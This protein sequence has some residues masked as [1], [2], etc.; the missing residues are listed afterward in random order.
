MI[1]QNLFNYFSVIV[2]S[3]DERSI[4]VAWDYSCNHPGVFYKVYLEHL[5]WKACATGQKDNTRGPGTVKTLTKQSCKPMFHSPTTVELCREYG[6]CCCWS[7]VEEYVGSI[8][9]LSSPHLVDNCTREIS[10]QGE[11]WLPLV[12]LLLYS[13]CCYIRQR[14]GS[15]TLNP[16]VI[17]S[18]FNCL[19]F[20][21]NIALFTWTDILWYIFATTVGIQI[22]NIQIMEPFK[23][24]TVYYWGAH[25]PIKVCYSTNQLHFLSVTQPMTWIMDFQSVQARA[26]Q[27]VAHQLE[28]P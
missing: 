19:V 28:V 16:S 1:A 7:T 15:L 22:T 20:F 14:T 26:P 2:V 21:T 4:S 6:L 24:R 9:K 3:T 25:S 11:G 17:K 12:Q 23:L 13:N 8:L 10:I 27:L 18:L 5:E